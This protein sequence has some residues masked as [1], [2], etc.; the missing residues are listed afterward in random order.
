M[1]KRRLALAAAIAP[2]VPM[3]P[4]VA[5]Y[6]AQPIAMIF[7]LGTSYVGFLVVLPIILYLERR[8]QLDFSWLI[9]VGAVGGTMAFSGFLIAFA[10]MLGS[11]PRFS[12][13][14]IAVVWGAPLG[15]AVALAFGLIAG[16]PGGSPGM[17]K[18]PRAL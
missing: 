14:W 5:M 17:R 11:F 15:I 6:G 18:K 13:Y 1:N 2:L 10:F 7:S 3:F 8:G 4:V 9:V 12:D 16:I